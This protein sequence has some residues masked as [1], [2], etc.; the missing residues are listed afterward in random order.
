MTPPSFFP[1]AFSQIPPANSFTYV[2]E[3]ER[4]QLFYGGEGVFLRLFSVDDNF[5]GFFP[6]FTAPF[7][8]KRRRK[9]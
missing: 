8:K 4:K 3:G 9:C 5:K 6:S 1:R 2:Q 7:S